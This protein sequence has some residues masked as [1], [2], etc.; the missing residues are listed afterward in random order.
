MKKPDWDSLRRDIGGQFIGDP[1]T[2]LYFVPLA[3]FLSMVS[4][5]I[6]GD[7]WIFAAKMVAN[8]I[9]FAGCY[10]LLLLF[11]VTIFRERL[12]L[13][14][15]L[16][17]V[18]GA[19]MAVGALKV[20]LTALV[21]GTLTG[22]WGGVDP[23]AIRIVAGAITGAWFFPVAAIIMS[24]QDRYRTAREVVVAERLRVTE[25]SGG[26][27]P[28]DDAPTRLASVLDDARKAISEHR[29]HPAALAASLTELLDDKIRPLSRELLAGRGRKTRD[30]SAW[31]LLRIV[32]SR[33]KYWPT[34]TTLA[35]VL[36]AGPL[37]VSTVGWAEGI[38]RLGILGAVAWLVLTALGRVPSG[39]ASL[40]TV[41]FVGA[42]LA[43]AGINELLAQSVFGNFGNFS[44]P[45]AIFLSSTLFGAL[46]LL[47]G[48]VR[49]TRSELDTLLGEL[50]TILGKDY[51]EG[52]IERELVKARHRELAHVI[53]GRLQNQILGV[54]L[55]LSKNPAAS[56]TEDLMRE[57]EL[58]DAAITARD[59]LGRLPSNGNLSQELEALVARWAGIIDVT[60]TTHGAETAPARDVPVLVG[61]AEEGITNAVRHGLASSVTI[62][63]S[64]EEDHWRLSV[65]DN[66]VGPRDGLPGIG[67]LT[68]N[69]VAG[70]S[71][72]LSANR[73]G[74]GSILMADIPS[75]EKH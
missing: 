68:L 42:V 36:S 70:N 40:G 54:V 16:S 34:L 45:F 24:L 23:L 41:V 62:S 73:S 14:I 61:V 9:A 26:W 22:D 63:V 52:Q 13:T 15:S 6:E 43:N 12:R 47:L 65:S 56:T 18:I 4:S 31:E 7:P 74:V 1:R 67:T 10:G 11:R 48:A 17:V 19:G 20:V 32:V 21:S 25:A 35:L 28:H 44:I 39:R 75:T 27:H 49:V 46:A 8:A 2:F 37:I 38:G 71:W 59:P 33:H 51:L 57:I 3:W 58:L 50:T 66:G 53:H 29:D 5:D 55:A 30:S 72:S 69:K 60:V 64:K